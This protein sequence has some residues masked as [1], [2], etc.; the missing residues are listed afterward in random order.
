M[1]STALP[2][3]ILS[4]CSSRSGIVSRRMKIQSYGFQHLVGQSF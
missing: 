4:I 3:E 2:R 1:Q